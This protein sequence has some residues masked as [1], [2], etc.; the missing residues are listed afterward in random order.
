MSLLNSLNGDYNP[1]HIDPK[2]AA[3]AGFKTPILHGLASWNMSCAAILRELCNSD[4]AR[5]KEFQARFASPVLPGNTLIVEMWKGGNMDGDG[6]EDV[7]FRVLVKETGK[8]VLS[9]GRA[10]VKIAAGGS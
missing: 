9:N 2:A 1:L 8:V 6:F 10:R 7:V 3:S 4:T 5:M